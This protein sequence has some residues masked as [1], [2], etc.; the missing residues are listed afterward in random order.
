M[1]INNGK[2]DDT[3]IF[4]FLMGNLTKDD[5]KKLVLTEVHNVINSYIVANKQSIKW[6]N[7]KFGFLKGILT[8]NIAIVKKSQVVFCHN[9]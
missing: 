5:T 1:P 3:L 6:H 9:R 7:W 2:V 8:K 4:K